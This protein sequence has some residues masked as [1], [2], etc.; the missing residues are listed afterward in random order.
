VIDPVVTFEQSLLTRNH[1]DVWVPY[2][3]ARGL[4]AQALAEPRQREVALKMAAA[5]LS[6]L[7]PR[8]QRLHD[9]RQWQRWVAQP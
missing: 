6:S 9:V 8:L 7:P 5:L 4:Y 1:G 3:L 2:E